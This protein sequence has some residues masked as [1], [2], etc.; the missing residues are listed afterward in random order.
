MRQKK[1]PTKK[2]IKKDRDMTGGGGTFSS[3]SMTPWEDEEELNA[4]EL[5]E[6][7]GNHLMVQLDTQLPQIETDLNDIN[8][9][10]SLVPEDERLF[11][12]RSYRSDYDT[13]VDELEDLIDAG[14]IVSRDDLDRRFASIRQAL[15][16]RLMT[17]LD[18]VD[19]KKY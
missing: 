15:D 14:V 11:A 1:E 4:E 6:E 19:R 5:A 12:I 13:R 18:R 8:N 9:F 16:R 17:F 7:L 2:E 3:L 10:Y